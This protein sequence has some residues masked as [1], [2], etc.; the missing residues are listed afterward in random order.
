[1][2]KDNNRKL[3]RALGL[4]TAVVLGLSAVPVLPAQAQ[5]QP[6]PLPMVVALNTGWTKFSWLPGLQGPLAFTTIFISPDNTA[7]LTLPALLTFTASAQVNC[8]AT[9]G[10]VLVHV[11]VYDF[12]QLILSMPYSVSCAPRAVPWDPTLI[13]TADDYLNDPH[14]LK[15]S[16]PI[17]NG[18]LWSTTSRSHR[19][20][21]AGKLAGS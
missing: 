14:F 16:V 3:A 7:N 17:A 1:M 5:V 21:S 11:Q 10:N 18:S 12:S 2:R 9:G 8:P 15:F 4:L 13:R 20:P 6:L 19:C